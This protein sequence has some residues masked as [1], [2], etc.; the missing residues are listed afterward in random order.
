MGEKGDSEELTSSVTGLIGQIDAGDP[1][2][3]A[4]L[5]AIVYDELRAIAR[6]L[7]RGRSD[8][9]LETT[10]IVHEFFGRVL[11]DGRLSQMKNRRYFYA[12]AADQMRR[13]LIDHWRRTRTQAAGGHLHREPIEP[14][15]DQL[16]DSA[17][18]RAGGDLAAL[19]EALTRLKSDRPRPHEVA[20]LK[21]FVGL[22]NEEIATVLD[23]SVDTVK[24]DWQL[25]RAR[26]GVLLGASA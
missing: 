21:F 3:Q 20:Q 10:E 15:L 14:W 17:A 6:R 11:A 16:T 12:A 18:S 9:A 1:A 26:L 25:A 4:E 22:G 23:V 24:R 7:R 5:C 13:I 8:G 19:D 2:A